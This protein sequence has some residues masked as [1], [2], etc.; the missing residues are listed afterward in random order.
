[1]CNTE[2]KV[3]ELRCWLALVQMCVHMHGRGV[4]TCLCMV[5]QNEPLRRFLA[6]VTPSKFKV[7][8]RQECVCV[9]TG[10]FFLKKLKPGGE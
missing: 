1:M 3:E 2:D 8:L 4:H 7:G 6:V 9:C 5:A 10:R